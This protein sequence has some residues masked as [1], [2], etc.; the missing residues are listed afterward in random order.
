VRKSEGIAR[1]QLP[2]DQSVSKHLY[3]SLAD[4]M[5]HLYVALEIEFVKKVKSFFVRLFVRLVVRLVVRKLLI[6]LVLSGELP[7][8]S[9][10]L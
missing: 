5:R 7:G 3:S 6:F 9:S 8:F 4:A 1:K 2:T 10:S